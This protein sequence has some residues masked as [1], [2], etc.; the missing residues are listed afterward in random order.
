MKRKLVLSFSIL[1]IIIRGDLRKEYIN[2]NAAFDEIQVARKSGE[3]WKSMTD[4]VSVGLSLFFLIN[5]W[6]TLISY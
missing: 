2:A 1:L 3:R 5:H 4:E 6:W